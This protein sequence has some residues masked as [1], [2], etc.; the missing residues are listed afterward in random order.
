VAPYAAFQFDPLPIGAAAWTAVLVLPTADDEEGREPA[1]A[2]AVALTAAI[3]LYTARECEAALPLFAVANDE[4]LIAAGVL[5]AHSIYFYQ[6]GCQVALK[7]FA[8]AERSYRAVLALDQDEFEWEGDKRTFQTS[9]A[10]NLAWLYAN[11]QRSAKAIR[12]LDQFVAV[13]FTSYAGR[14]IA[15]TVERAAL[16]LQ[17]GEGD[18][19]VDELTWFLESLAAERATQSTDLNSPSSI[20]RFYVSPSEEAWLYTERG[21]LYAQR[22]LLA[23]ALADYETALGIDDTY[24]L[25]HF[26][27][28]L[29]AMERNNPEAAIN[30]FTTFLQLVP[31]FYSYYQQD[32]TAYVAEA[33]A[34]LVAL[35]AVD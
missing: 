23:A 12:L 9:A 29:L 13:E 7:D 11:T 6:A 14:E 25:A 21:W 20:R 5:V 18:K 22:G 31:D 8:A 10:T 26:R 3:T 16:Y 34:H 15:W 24:P 27:R 33:K 19:A 28:A 30:S 35:G 4:D 1:F 2:A 17:L 32:L